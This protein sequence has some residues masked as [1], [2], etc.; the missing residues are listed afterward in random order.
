MA[1]SDFFD[2]GWKLFEKLEIGMVFLG[3]H[4][5]PTTILQQKLFII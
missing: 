4:I 5:L 3:K 1:F 2:D